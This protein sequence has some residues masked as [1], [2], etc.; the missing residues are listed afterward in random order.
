MAIVVAPDSYA[1]LIF[2]VAGLPECLDLVET[3]EQAVAL[4]AA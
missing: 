2:E 4:A 3:R 1:R